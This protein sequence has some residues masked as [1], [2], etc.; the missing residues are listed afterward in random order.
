MSD[1]TIRP[2]LAAHIPAVASMLGALEPWTYYGI[3]ASAWERSLRALPS[4]DLAF[5]AADG[6][7]IVGYIQYRLGGTFALS[8]YIRTLAVRADQGGRGLGR[9]ILAFAEEMILARGPNVFLLCSDRN[10]QAQRFYERLGYVRCGLLP[11]YV[12][13]GMDEI[14][15]RKSTGPIRR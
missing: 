2:M 13:P 10:Q 14:I 11:G 1:L 8:G 3:D 4:D 6:D 15:Y 5:V 7:E 12:L 9:R